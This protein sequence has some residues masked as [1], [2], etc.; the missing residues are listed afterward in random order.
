MGNVACC[1]DYTINVVGNR[2]QPNFVFVVC[3]YEDFRLLNSRAKY[4]RYIYRIPCVK[5][6]TVRLLLKF[7]LTTN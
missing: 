4:V 5:N 7:Q 6:T 2:L 1:S 3:L